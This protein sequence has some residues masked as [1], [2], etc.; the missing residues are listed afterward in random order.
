[1]VNIQ[2]PRKLLS[3]AIG[4][5]VA[6]A[7]V[8]FHAGP[9]DAQTPVYVPAQTI[10]GPG[11]F[12]SPLSVTADSAGNIIVP[13]TYHQLVKVFDPSGQTVLATYGV[14]GRPSDPFPGLPSGDC[15]N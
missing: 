3:L 4:A 15:S 8:A 14:P 12:S 1:M 11:G 10:S 9:A 13:D 6:F 2:Q 7:V 5:C